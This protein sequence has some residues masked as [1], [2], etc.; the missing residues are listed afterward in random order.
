MENEF[1]PLSCP[2]C[3][4]APEWYHSPTRTF[5]PFE[6][7]VVRWQSSL[8]CP[9]CRTPHCS[10]FGEVLWEGG[11]ALAQQHAMRAALGKWNRRTAQPQKGGD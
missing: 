8:A 4:A 11:N 9:C 10:G 5:P 6:L 7:R 2:F 3:G 1:T